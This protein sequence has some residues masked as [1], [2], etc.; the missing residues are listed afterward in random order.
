L[1]RS[2]FCAIQWGERAGRGNGR[3]GGEFGH[4]GIIADNGKRREIELQRQR[5]IE[6]RRQ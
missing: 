6:F 3:S 2:S 4:A 5:H 1:C